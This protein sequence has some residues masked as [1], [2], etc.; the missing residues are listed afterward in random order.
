M[1]PRSPLLKIK[2]NVFMYFR[3][4]S[5][6]QVMLLMLLTYRPVCNRIV[7]KWKLIGQDWISVVSSGDR[8][9]V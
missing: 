9:H 1:H 4:S 3:Y 5:R 6:L 2:Y 8:W 7:L